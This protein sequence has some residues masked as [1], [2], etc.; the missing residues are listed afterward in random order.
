[1]PTLR[2][3][4]AGTPP[5]AARALAAILDAGFDVPVAIT[6]PDRPSGR[7]LAMLPSAV[8]ALAQERAI[9]VLQPAS[10]RTEEARGALFAVPLDVLVMLAVLSICMGLVSTASFDA[11]GPS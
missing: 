1:M 4:F 8:K 5:F 11:C 9:A 3:G 10:L 6:Q 7:G 2:V